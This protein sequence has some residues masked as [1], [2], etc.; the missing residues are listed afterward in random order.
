MF[1]ADAAQLSF[2]VHDQRQRSEPKE[3]DESDYLFPSF[4]QPTPWQHA[5][6]SVRDGEPPSTEDCVM[7]AEFSEQE[8]PRPVVTNIFI[9]KP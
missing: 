1:G 8:G 7:I 9:R 5:R 4:T 2:T 6:A 3:S